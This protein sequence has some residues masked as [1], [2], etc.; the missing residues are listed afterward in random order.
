[1]A[2][3]Q[4]LFKRITGNTEQA[5]KGSS[6]RYQLLE[7]LRQKHELIDV[8]VIR[9]G[10]IYQSVIVTIDEKNS[11]LIIDDLF[12]VEGVSELS[13]NEPVEIT[14][15]T[16]KLM[17]NFK[18][19]IVGRKPKK[20]GTMF[21]LELPQDIG[22]DH[23]RG[24]FRV[25][26]D[27]EEDISIDLG[28]KDEDL[29]SAHIV[30]LSP[31]GVKIVFNKEIEAKLNHKKIFPGTVIHLPDGVDIAC[32]LEICSVF[33][34]ATP[35]PHSLAGCKIIISKPQHRI[36]IDQYLALVQRKQRR[37]ENREFS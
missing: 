7:D 9:T 3:L 33:L 2:L 37:R 12:P 35:S 23:S 24:A 16:H 22:Q 34:I 6:A 14:S 30:N 27:C 29:L 1:M 11:R 4:S 21:K 13:E 28:T 36:K 5:P 10:K 19:R 15:H 18:T 17:V 26:V 20:D 8:K 32:Q 31:E 25:F